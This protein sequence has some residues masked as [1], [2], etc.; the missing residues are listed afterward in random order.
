MRAAPRREDSGRVPATGARLGPGAFGRPPLSP[1]FFRLPSATRP[2]PA[3]PRRDCAGRFF[4]PVPPRLPRPM[5]ARRRRPRRS[6]PSPA[7]RPTPRH[8]RAPRRRAEPVAQGQDVVFATEPCRG[9]TTAEREPYRFAR[10]QRGSAP[11]GTP[12]PRRTSRR[13]RPRP[14]RV[15]Q[16][17]S[18]SVE[19][20]CFFDWFKS[21]VLRLTRSRRPR[22][23]AI[24]AVPCA[25]TPHSHKN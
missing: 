19:A 13:G 4:A 21:E 10:F 24:G 1:F 9:P 14:A 11:Q 7:T 17:N 20:L 22:V 5:S 25:P 12:G 3:P 16:E 6:A 23:E 2:L 18:R 8:L 15:A